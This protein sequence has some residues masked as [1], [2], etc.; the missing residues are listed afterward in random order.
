LDLSQRLQT[1]LKKRIRKEK[2]YLD[3]SAINYLRGLLPG[4]Q[5]QEMRSC[6][7]DEWSS[8][9]RGTK[10]LYDLIDMFRKPVNPP[11]KKKSKKVKQK[12]DKMKAFDKLS[13]DADMYINGLY[14][15]MWSLWPKWY[16]DINPEPPQGDLSKKDRFNEYMQVIGSKINS[17]DNGIQ[18]DR[19]IYNPWL[20]TKAKL[21]PKVRLEGYRS[22]DY[23]NPHRRRR[24]KPSGLYSGPEEDPEE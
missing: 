9:E 4:I 1:K 24:V 22:G 11:A 2:F 23:Q 3:E 14:H 6:G 18:R 7:S 5:I 15:L 21:Y 17:V 10:L 16:R 12:S 19:V 20:K 8:I 13:A